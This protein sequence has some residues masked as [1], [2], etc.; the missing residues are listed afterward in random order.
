MDK[1][2]YV[3]MSGAKQSFALQSIINHNVAN[4]S[5]TG[6]RADLFAAQSRPIPGT[7]FPTRVNPL[8]TSNGW[9]SAV[10][11]QEATGRELDVAIRGPGYIAVLGRDGTE[12]YTRAG[13]LQTNADGQLVTSGGHPVLGQQGPITLPNST[14]VAIGSDGTISVVAQGQGPEAI[15]T[16][17]RIKLV[18]PSP[19]SL[20]KG[21][22]GLL[23]TSDGTTAEADASVQIVPGS[24]EASNVNLADSMM[25]MILIARRYE[26][27]V[28]LMSVANDNAAATTRLVSSSS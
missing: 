2:L 6:F 25:N 28:K 7:G 8:A 18:N 16:V 9:S 13:D 19:A 11:A 1:L 20:S 14:H 3:A 10:G 22:D 26:T 12:A 23:R 21:S 17:D 27:Q 24:I 15:S 4:A 5:T